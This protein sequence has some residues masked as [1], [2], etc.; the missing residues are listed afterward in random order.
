MKRILSAILVA[1]SFLFAAC[2]NGEKIY[3]ASKFGILPNTGEDM[4]QE[5]AKAIETIKQLECFVPDIEER[6]KAGKPKLTQIYR[7]FLLSET[8]GA[9]EGL[10]SYSVILA[11]KKHPTTKNELASLMNEL[12]EEYWHK[13]CSITLEEF[14]ATIAAHS[15]QEYRSIFE[16]FHDRY[17]NFEKL[18]KYE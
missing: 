10:E 8:Y 15:P 5:V 1:S 6:I 7:N 14:V 9:H 16:R 2:G 13:I 17:L 11:P 12:R 3:Y 4:T 18:A